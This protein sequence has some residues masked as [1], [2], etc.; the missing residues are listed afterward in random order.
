LLI[1]FF[2]MQLFNLYPGD[3]SDGETPQSLYTFI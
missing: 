2:S 1:T 3:Y